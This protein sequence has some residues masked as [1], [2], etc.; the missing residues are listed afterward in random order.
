VSVPS[1]TA[2]RR[3]IGFGAHEGTCSGTAT[4]GPALLWCRRC[5]TLRREHL[6]RQFAEIKALF[7][8]P[9]AD[10]RSTDA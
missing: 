2:E 1:L 6:D 9:R 3:C 4:V 5:E 8:P 7:N 10:E